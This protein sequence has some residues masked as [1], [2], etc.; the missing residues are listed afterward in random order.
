M[1]NILNNY[2]KTF[3]KKRHFRN[4]TNNSSLYDYQSQFCSTF[5]PKL[6]QKLSKATQFKLSI[7]ATYQLLQNSFKY[8]TK[9]NGE[10]I[11]LSSRTSRM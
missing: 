4:S 11:L 1:P 5:V 6:W 7:T 3:S 2:C 10:F 9:A 8:S